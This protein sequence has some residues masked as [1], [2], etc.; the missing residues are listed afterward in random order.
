MFLTRQRTAL[1]QVFLKNLRQIILKIT[2]GRLEKVSH[3]IV[4]ANFIQLL[5]NVFPGRDLAI[6]SVF[7]DFCG[8][9]LEALK[10]GGGWAFAAHPPPIKPV[11]AGLI[12]PLSLTRQ[13][14]CGSAVRL[15]TGCPGSPGSPLCKGLFKR[16]RPASTIRR[17]PS[18]W[19]FTTV[20]LEK[21]VRPDLPVYP[22]L[23]SL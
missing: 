5:E 17:G 23:G 7:S 14:P 2:G 16:R 9:I 8:K 10:R 21:R 20:G 1:R 6:S 4:C 3:K 19:T 12:G 13:H 22:P 15:A 11:G 18:H